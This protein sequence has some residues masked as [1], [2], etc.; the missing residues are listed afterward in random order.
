[1]RDWRKDHPEAWRAVRLKH[2]YGL[3]VQD[4]ERMH[5]EQN[6]LCAI[7]GQPETLTAPSGKLT[8]LTIDHDHETD[9]VRGLLCRKCNAAL[10][11]LNDSVE[12]VRAALAYLEKHKKV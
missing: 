6:G 9:V 3:T 7:C 5:A 8:R 11:S 4:Y 12:I 2:L 10:G 1:M